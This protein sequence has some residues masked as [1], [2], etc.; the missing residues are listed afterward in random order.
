[1]NLTATQILGIVLFYGMSLG[2]VSLASRKFNFE[3][4]LWNVVLAPFF[5]SLAAWTCMDD[6]GRDDLQYP[7]LSMLL[8]FLGPTALILIFPAFPAALFPLVFL[9]GSYIL[10]VIQFAISMF[11]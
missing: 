3:W 6:F 7:M 10:F 8:L 5:Y 11:F 2:L 1:M 4:S 9:V